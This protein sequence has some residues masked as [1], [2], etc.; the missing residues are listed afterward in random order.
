MESKRK[1]E[2]EILSGRKA[3]LYKMKIPE[4]QDTPDRIIIEGY[5]DGYFL[6]SGVWVPGP[7]L[8]FPN[9]YYMWGVIDAAEIKPHT[10]DIFKVVKP[11]PSYLII[12][13]GKYCVNFDKSFY[14]HFEKFKIKVDIMPT[15]EAMIQFNS[16]NDDELSVAAALIP[17]NL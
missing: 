1:T 16:C 12:G 9:R 3:F 10:L 15:E 17:N 11:K 4:V 6:I 14:E 8:L 7:V 2:E 13:T 5:E